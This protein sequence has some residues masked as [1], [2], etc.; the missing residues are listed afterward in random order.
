[1]LRPI[2]QGPGESPRR[3]STVMSEPSNPTFFLPHSLLRVFC[4]PDGFTGRMRQL[5]QRNRFLS[6]VCAEKSLFSSSHD[7]VPHLLVHMPPRL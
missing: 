6:A 3:P 1:M 2:L 5:A 7:H 4:V